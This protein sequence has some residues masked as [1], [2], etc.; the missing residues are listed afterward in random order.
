M[1][2]VGNI[3]SRAH[4][5]LDLPMTTPIRGRDNDGLG[6]S[7]RSSTRAKTLEVCQGPDC[8]GCGGGAVLLELEE[9]AQEE[10]A[11]SQQ[12]HFGTDVDDVRVHVVR[13]GCRNFCSMGPNVHDRSRQ[14]QYS[15]VKGLKECQDVFRHVCRPLSEA[16]AK[17][18]PV[19]IT[20]PPVRSSPVTRMLTL[21]ANRERWSFLR[22]VATARKVSRQ[23]LRAQRPI[24]HKELTSVCG[25][26]RRAAAAS[27]GDDN[28]EL[29]RIHRRQQ[30]Y[31][32][33]LESDSESDESD[34]SEDESEE[35]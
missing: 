28:A 11:H 31:T 4:H 19:R 24:L 9:L 21:R 13:G 10:A 26:E 18:T 27:R 2:D 20:D 17:T 7:G 29:E 23:I 3:R 22:H 1:H 12:Q 30:R 33:Y 35:E 34:E 14:H 6:A 8:F 16:D 15:Q 32:K 25:L 5:Y